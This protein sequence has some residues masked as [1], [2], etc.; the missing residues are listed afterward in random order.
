MTGRRQQAFTLIEAAAVLVLIGLMASAGALSLRSAY[1]GSQ[2]NDVV[3]RVKA[4]DRSARSLVQLTGQSGAIH[5]D[6]AKGS[7]RFAQN[8]ESHAGL[9][10][11]VLPDGFK[12][13]GVG[14]ASSLSSGGALEIPCSALGQTPVY[15]L[16]ISGPK[17]QTRL[18]VFAGLTGQVTE[19]EHD[20]SFDLDK[21]LSP[22]IDAD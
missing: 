14:G 22:G 18:L 19:L 7:I 6:T 13:T 17:E 20:A 11:V 10:P 2:M 16:S 5:I 3:S 1:R 8:H 12:L 4:L 15:S 21:L 9:L